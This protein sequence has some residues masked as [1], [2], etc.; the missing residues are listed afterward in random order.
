MEKLGSY[1]YLLSFLKLH[2]TDWKTVFLYCDILQCV[3]IKLARHF[4]LKWIYQA[5]KVI[6]HVYV[7]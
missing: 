5:R 3:H 7:H 2:V 4:L 6:D 1:I